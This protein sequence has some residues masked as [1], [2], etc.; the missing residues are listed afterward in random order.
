MIGTLDRIGKELMQAGTL[1]DAQPQHGRQ[2]GAE[3]GCRAGPAGRTGPDD[4][5]ALAVA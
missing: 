4:K 5:P 3:S 2:A 1:C